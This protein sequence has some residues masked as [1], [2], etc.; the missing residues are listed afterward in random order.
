VAYEMLWR[1]DGY[2]L[3]AMQ[4]V[5]EHPLLGVGVGRFTG[6]STAYHQRITGR[7]IP[8]DNAQNLWRHTLAEQGILGL[9]PILWL[10]LLT[11]RSLV[12]PSPS[13]AALLMRVMLAGLGVALIV[14]YPVQDAAIAVT[15]AT[16]VA[17]VARGRG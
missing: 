15:L 8:P 3:A 12:A 2:G 10:T 9:A 7:A 6:L 5:R 11:A 17:E 14:G 4:A 1:R 16:L 13:A